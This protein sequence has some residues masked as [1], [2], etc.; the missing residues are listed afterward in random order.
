MRQLSSMLLALVIPL[1]AGTFTFD[2]NL[3]GQANQADLIGLSAS[4][5]SSCDP[6]NC[7]N[8]D[9]HSVNDSGAYTLTFYGGTGAGSFQFL[10]DAFGEHST[11]TGNASASVTVPGGHA[12]SLSLHDYS[13]PIIPMVFG[14][15]V[16]GSYSLSANATSTGGPYFASASISIIGVYDANGVKIP[17]TL[18]YEVVSDSAAQIPEPATTVPILVACTAAGLVASKRRKH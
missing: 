11:N 2:P 16:T 13:A 15:P 7:S 6:R 9:S 14:V 18:Q 4:A 17:A 10:L 3:P 12:A 1:S 5:S 8:R